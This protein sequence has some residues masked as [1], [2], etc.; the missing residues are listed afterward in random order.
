MNTGKGHC[1]RCHQS[2]EKDL[3]DHVSDCYGGEPTMCRKECGE[4]FKENIS[5]IGLADYEW[6]RLRKSIDQLI[7]DGSFSIRHLEGMIEIIKEE[8]NNRYK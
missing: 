6:L 4:Y 8:I 7:K 1:L 3:L 5:T 2:F